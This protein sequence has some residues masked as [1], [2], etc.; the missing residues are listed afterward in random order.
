VRHVN[1]D[2]LDQLEPLLEEL[3]QLPQLRERKRGNFSRGSRGFLHFHAD[4]DDF[5][6]DV[7]LSTEYERLKVTNKDE[8]ADFIS[9]VKNSLGTASG[10]RS[11]SDSK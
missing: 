3:R 1:E 5:Y 9:E 10:P 8:R 7:R 6:A 4:G 2:D 11:S